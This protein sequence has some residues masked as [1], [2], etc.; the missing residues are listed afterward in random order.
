VLLSIKRDGRRTAHSVCADVILLFIYR[1]CV[2]CIAYFI[3]ITYFTSPPKS[4]EN[5]ERKRHESG[6][7]KQAGSEIPSL[8]L[9]YSKNLHCSRILGSKIENDERSEFH[10]QIYDINILRSKAM[11]GKIESVAK[12]K[13]DTAEGNVNTGEKRDGLNET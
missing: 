5:V 9:I 13:T 1:V 2:L 7:R 11:F 6:S 8:S 3:Y 4:A 12:S 10:N